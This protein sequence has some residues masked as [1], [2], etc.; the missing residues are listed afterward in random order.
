MFNIF[1]VALFLTHSIWEQVPNRSHQINLSMSQ[2]LTGTLLGKEE[3]SRAQLALYLQL[4]VLHQVGLRVPRD[5]TA[6]RSNT[7]K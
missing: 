2:W 3:W 7:Y 4:Q 6:T 5:L 1:C